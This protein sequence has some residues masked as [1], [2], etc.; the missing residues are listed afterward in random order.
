MF[1]VPHIGTLIW[2]T[3]I[4]SILLFILS[5]FAWKP[6]LKALD[7]REKTVENALTGAKDAEKKISSLKDEQAA[8][9]LTAKQEKEN[10]IKEG[11]DQRNKIIAEAREKA[12][13][14]ADKIVEEA[15]KNIAREKD[16]ALLDI[17]SQIASL[18]IEIATKIVHAEMEDKEQH[19]KFVQKLIKEIDLN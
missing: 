13:A 17:K 7:D 4:F 8:V 11:I 16:A 15:R 18:S 19:K 5:K 2:T 3:L 9:I 10:I 12:Q 1:L 14:E 6:L